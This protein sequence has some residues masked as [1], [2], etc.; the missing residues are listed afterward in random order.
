MIA[1]TKRVL[2]HFLAFS[3]LIAF[4]VAAAYLLYLPKFFSK[5]VF[6][7]SYSSFVSNQAVSE[8][9]L[10]RLTNTEI[11]ERHEYLRIF[12]KYPIGDTKVVVSVVATYFFLVRPDEIDFTLEDETLLVHARGLYLQNPVAFDSD[13]VSVSGEENWFGKNK[14]KLASELERGI[15]DKLSVRGLLHLPLARRQAYE[16]LARSVHDVFEN[17]GLSGYYEE[18]IV[19]FANDE[20]RDYQKFSFDGGFCNTLNCRYDIEIGDQVI[21]LGRFKE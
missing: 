6:E 18:I 1:A 21:V 5:E 15:S 20:Q 4:I 13:S 8:L 17:L 11:F 7:D 10:V 16:A 2:I 3:G 19:T 9:V 14:E 12:E